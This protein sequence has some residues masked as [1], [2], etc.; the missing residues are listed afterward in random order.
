MPPDEIEKL[1]QQLYGFGI[2]PEALQQ[3]PMVPQSYVDKKWNQDAGTYV[4]TEMPFSKPSTRQW[5]VSEGMRTIFS[6]EL[7][8]LGGAYGAPTMDYSQHLNP[9]LEGQQ[10]GTA[11]P[12]P[13]PYL[14][15]LAKSQ[16]PDEQA[17]AQGIKQG[18]GLSNIKAQILK[19]QDPNK[20]EVLSGLADK[21]YDEYVSGGSGAP[22]T[23]TSTDSGGGDVGPYGDYRGTGEL[24]PV[25]Q[26][27]ANAGIPMPWEEYTA[28]NVPDQYMPKNAKKTIA[29]QARQGDKF[30]KSVERFIEQAKKRQSEDHHSRRMAEEVLQNQMRKSVQSGAIPREKAR[31]SASTAPTS[32]GEPQAR[33]YG[34]QTAQPFTGT[35]EEWVNTFFPQ[36]GSGETQPF[37][38]NQQNAWVAP[39][40]QWAGGSPEAHQQIAQDL[41]QWQQQKDVTDQKKIAAAYAQSQG[42][43]PT[44]DSIKARV[45]LARFLGLDI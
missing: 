9:E 1:L 23:G 10:P 42:A 27:Y 7:A 3:F 16:D 4:P 26:M 25:E 22:Q 13:T 45:A 44:T 35:G 17:I 34:D 12:A 36:Q 32:G 14:D 29:T 21:A 39:D 6:P 28:E 33:Q 11:E 18:V 19:V 8:M 30:L 40:P 43:S 41:V 37:I 31:Y 15:A 2:T 38:Q 5:A 24:T 20:Q